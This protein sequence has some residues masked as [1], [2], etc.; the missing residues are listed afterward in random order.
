MRVTT[1][2]GSGRDVVARCRDARNVAA[3]AGEELVDLSEGVAGDRD[4]HETGVSL[5]AP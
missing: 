4:G 2:A 3:F 1:A 5:L